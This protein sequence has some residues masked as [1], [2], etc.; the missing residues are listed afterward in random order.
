[1]KIWQSVYQAR[2]MASRLL[3]MWI[4]KGQDFL[5]LKIDTTVSFLKK[6]LINIPSIGQWPPPKQDSVSKILWGEGGQYETIQIGNGFH[7]ETRETHG[8]AF[9]VLEART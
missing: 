3:L 6:L 2:K 4:N 1:M 8:L 7:T 9:M 5:S